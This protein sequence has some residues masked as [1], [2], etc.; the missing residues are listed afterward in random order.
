MHNAAMSENNQGPS[1][2]LVGLV[3]LGFLAAAV[4]VWWIDP[5]GQWA[6][7]AKGGM[8]RIGV[9]F[10]CLW[11]ALP[12]RFGSTPGTKITLKLFFIVIGI[13][14]ALAFR[15]KLFMVLLPFLGVI[16]FIAVLFKPRTT[17]R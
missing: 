4:A 9:V 15:P 14:A 16:T 1:R 5:D 17:Q 3:A 2:P 7:G 12:G 11:L 13:M 10:V 6:E 8:V